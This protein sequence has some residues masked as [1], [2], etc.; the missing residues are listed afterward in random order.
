MLKR[1][2]EAKLAKQAEIMEKAKEAEKLRVDEIRAL[3]LDRI[4][5]SVQG[6][7]KIP[8]KLYLDED[9]QS[10]LSFAVLADFSRNMLEE[11]PPKKFL[12]LMTEARKLKL[13]QNRLLHIPDELRAMV[14]LEVLEMDTNRLLDL[15]TG[16]SSLSGLQRLDISNNQIT[17]LP[18]ELG[19]CGN[20]RYLYAH[21]N[22]LTMLPPSLGICSC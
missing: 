5:F 11:L 20:L 21:S 7:R 14:S 13:S 12:F 1:Q 8:A 6:L 3:G 18:S 16:I 4:D 15:P 10:K 2:E 9:S 17:Y 19:M 22:K